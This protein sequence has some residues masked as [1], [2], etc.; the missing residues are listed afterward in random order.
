MTE[1]L[2]FG[3]CVRLGRGMPRPRVPLRDRRRSNLPHGVPWGNELY[4]E[5]CGIERGFLQ[6]APFSWFQLR[7]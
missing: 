4:F 6:K 1:R 7:A 3:R 2:I 5:I